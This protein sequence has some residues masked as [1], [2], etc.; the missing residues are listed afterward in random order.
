MFIF[1]FKPALFLVFHI[2]ADENMLLVASNKSLESS[3]ILTDPS[4]PIC[5][6][7]SVSLNFN[8]DPEHG[9]FS[10]PLLC[11]L[12]QIIVLLSWTVEDFSNHSLSST[13]ATYSQ[14]PLFSEQQPVDAIK[15]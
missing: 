14:P 5:K 12:A 15:A 2:V 10:P 3:M 7:I 9:Y 4:H 13:H 6:E 1:S 11:H 8:I